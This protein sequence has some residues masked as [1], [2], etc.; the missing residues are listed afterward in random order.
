MHASSTSASVAL[1]L[2]GVVSVQV[3]AALATT[4][5]DD[6]GPAGTVLLRVAL[7]ALV[8]AAIWRPAVRGMS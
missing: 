2:A 7:A 6:L 3:G 4:L 5:F 1:V 8:L